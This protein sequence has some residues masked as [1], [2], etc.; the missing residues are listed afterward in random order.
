MFFILYPP[1][2]PSQKMFYLCEIVK[3]FTFI[4]QM[5]KPTENI[6]KKKSLGVAQ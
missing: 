5:N 4:L 1:L 6:S 2:P 3:W